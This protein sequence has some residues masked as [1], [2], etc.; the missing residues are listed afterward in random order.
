VTARKKAAKAATTRPRAARKS[1]TKSG[2]LVAPDGTAMVAQPHGG[3][4][5]EG[6]DH[7]RPGRPRNEVRE[8]AAQLLKDKLLP[9]AVEVIGASTDGD[10]HLRAI[11][12]LT[13]VGFN[14]KIRVAQTQA[15]GR[16]AAAAASKS[17]S[18]A[19]VEVHVSGGPTGVERATGTDG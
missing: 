17:G 18:S 13:E 3:A 10:L 15:A 7:A 6:G 11:E 4:L 9:R 19:S 1:G 12:K 14:E 16:A 8:L 5:K 2:T